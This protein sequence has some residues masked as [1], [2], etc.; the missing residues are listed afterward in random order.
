MT[1]KQELLEFWKDHFEFDTRLLRV[2]NEVDRALFVPDD[3]K[4]EAYDD[5]PLPI[6]RGKTIS[7]PTA[8]MTMTAALDVQEGDTVF[9]VGTGSG[10]QTALLAK[11]AGK[12]GKVISSEVIPELIHFSRANLQRAGILNAE[13]IEE[14]GSKGWETE[15]P[16]DRIMITAAAREFPKEL[17]AQLRV[18]GV[19]VAPLGDEKEQTMTRATKLDRGIELEFLGPFMFSPLYGKYGFEV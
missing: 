16:Y 13:V 4:E 6:L 9:E 7:Q 2:F 3:L 12:K 18:G 17:L 15:A 5:R 10:Y 8:V 14:D 11:L 19:I 1:E